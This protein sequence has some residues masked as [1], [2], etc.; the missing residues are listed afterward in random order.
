MRVLLVSHVAPPHIGGVE[1][2]VLA[3]ALALVAAGHD[4][5]WITSDAGGAGQ[6][7]PRHERL[8][9]VRVRAWH[10]LERRFGIAFPLFA[11]SL[12]W[13]VAREAWRADVVHAHGL[14]FLPSP[15]A[16]CCARLFGRWSLCTDHGGLLR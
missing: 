9:V 2:L 3:E 13:Q 16:A 10:A 15:L 5:A 7:V 4:V 11:P 6:Q 8:R 12:A 1:N 14:V